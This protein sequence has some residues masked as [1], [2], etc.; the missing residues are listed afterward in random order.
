MSIWQGAA[1]LRVF[2]AMSLV[3]AVGAAP[4]VAPLTASGAPSPKPPVTVA[5]VESRVDAASLSLQNPIELL[6]NDV[7]TEIAALDWSKAPARRLYKVSAAIVTLES[8]K[9]DGTMA[10]TSCTVSV[11]IRE[12]KGGTLLAIL[13]GRARVED[14]LTASAGAQ[15]DAL[16]GAVRGAV[17]G[18]PEAIRSAR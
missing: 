4:I 5:E 14:A 12:A 13:E 1:R 6:K 8:K 17:A 16:T 18:I 9:V 10:R 11:S 3:L 7:E 15:R 2:R